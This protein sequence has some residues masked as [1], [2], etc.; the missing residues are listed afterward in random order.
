M[1]GPVQEVT[2]AYTNDTLTL[3]SHERW[4]TDPAP[5][6]NATTETANPNP[7]SGF[8]TELPEPPHAR[9]VSASI[10][11]PDGRQTATVSV[12][13][14]IELEVI[15]DILYDSVYILPAFMV[16]TEDGTLAFSVIHA[17]AT[18]E[19]YRRSRGRYRSVARIPSHFLTTGHHKVWVGLNT[20]APGKLIRHHEFEN[21]L[22]F[23]VHEVPSGSISALGPYI[24]VR[25][26]VRPL[27]KW[28]DEKI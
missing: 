19:N 15:Y 1:D 3:H 13:D 4:T 26:A 16:Y 20:P 23:F 11:A 21:A 28:R 18:P 12:A 14:R 9:L 22:S 2:D 10:R 24:M 5:I 27:I 8:R 7:G 25:G 17:E 6:I